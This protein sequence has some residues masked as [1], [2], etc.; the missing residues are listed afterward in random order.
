[1]THMENQAVVQDNKQRKS[2]AVDVKTYDLL[3]DIC[4]TDLRSIINQL[5]LLIEKE[6]KRLNTLTD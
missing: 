2:L 4:R 3:Q 5:K 1:M 6:H